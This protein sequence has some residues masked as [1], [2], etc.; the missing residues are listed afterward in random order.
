MQMRFKGRCWL[1][2]STLVLACAV[3]RPARGVEQS[4]DGARSRPLKA[5][6]R[7]VPGLSVY[8][9]GM[10]QGRSA[11]VESVERGL[12]SDSTRAVFA[13]LGLSAEIS[14]PALSFAPGRPRLFLHADTALSFDNEQ[15]VAT[16]ADPRPLKI[17][18]VQGTG[19]VVPLAG[20]EGRGSA[21]RIETQS[22]VVSAGIG[23]SFELP[24]WDRSL[25]IKPS[26]EWEWQED[27]LRQLFGDVEANGT[28]PNS[29]STPSC[30][31]LFLEAT[32]KQGFHS[33][34]PGLEIEVE[35]AR[36][37]QTVLTLYA[38]G[39]AYRLLGSRGFELESTGTW[40]T[41]GVPHPTRAPT[42]LRSTF[43]RDAWHYSI[44]VGVR[45]LWRPE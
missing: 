45:L 36:I 27:Q 32:G 15:P 13:I 38:S 22:P 3:G 21:T 9:L 11:T 2:A 25:R 37:R 44:G 12:H 39:R 41:N 33:L 28:D 31:T 18:S 34:G 35:S 6:E 42:V 43:E 10:I 1:A 20:T 14:T 30:R 17:N 29:C 7:W 23:L 26:I 24:V 19:V 8:G 16:E 5:S 40:V 4:A